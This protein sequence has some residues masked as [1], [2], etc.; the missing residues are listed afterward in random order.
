[1]RHERLIALVAIAGLVAGCK[2]VDDWSGLKR[3][4]DT[5]PVTQTDDGADR[6]RL[7]RDPRSPGARRR[8]AAGRDHRIDAQRLSRRSLDP[9]APALRLR[10]GRARAM[11]PATRRAPARCSARRSRRRRPCCPPSARWRTCMVRDLDARLALTRENETLRN[12]SDARRKT[13]ASP[14]SIGG[15]RRRRRRRTGCAASSSGP[16][17][18]SRPSRRSKAA[19]PQPRP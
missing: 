13:T 18:S 15:C 7:P 12:G 1:M 16:R 11:P 8:R 5:T 19:R 14:T 17:P 3:R 4:K 9:Q 6:R 10:A 2:N